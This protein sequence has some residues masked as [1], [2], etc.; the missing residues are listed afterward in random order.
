VEGAAP[1]AP[2]AAFPRLA[3]TAIAVQIARPE[4]LYS[5]AGRAVANRLRRHR[6]HQRS[7]LLSP[8]M[9]IKRRFSFTAN[10]RKTDS[11]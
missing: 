2:S 1:D 6:F 4:A 7:G 8:R 5:A 11:P 3:D 9:N 10:T